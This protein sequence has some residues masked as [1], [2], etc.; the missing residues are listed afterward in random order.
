[1]WNAFSAVRQLLARPTPRHTVQMLARLG[2]PHAS[3]GPLE[4]APRRG[5]GALIADTLER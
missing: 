1:M 3:D 5:V 2:H 4:P